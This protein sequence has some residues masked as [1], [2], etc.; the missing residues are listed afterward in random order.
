[1]N[2]ERKSIFIT[3]A[4]SGMGRATARLFASKGWFVGCYDV[5]AQGLD[6]LAEELGGDHSLLEVLDVGKREDYRGCLDR[7]SAQSGG[8]LDLLYS[9][10]GILGGGLFVDMPFETIE[11][12]V[13]TNLWGTINGIYE[14]MDLLK[15]TPNALCFT[16]SS[17]SAIF[18]A[19][20]LSIYTAT[21]HAVKGLT[22]ALS[23][24]LSAHG[25][26]AADVLPGLVA[27]GMM[28]ESQKRL[29]PKEGMWRV[30]PAEAVAEVV[31]NAY[32]DDTRLHWYVPADLEARERQV[33]ENPA[34]ARD[35]A[36][37]N[38]SGAGS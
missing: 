14:A 9:N 16:T 27:T 38:R 25:I 20:G 24:E 15:A 21:K 32:H 23:V 6:T 5:N 19:A 28:P 35:E 12:V 36:I 11:R 2:E 13:N 22:E 30:M 10:A 37:G 1:M 31:W 17:A 8:R 34:R 3:G 29:L 26:R 7:F 4:A 18:G 33:V